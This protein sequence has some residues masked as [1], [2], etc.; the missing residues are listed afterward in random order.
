MKKLALA[1]IALVAGF[2]IWQ[3]SA[4]V[5]QTSIAPAPVAPIAAP[6]Q[7]A[8][9]PNPPADISIEEKVQALATSGT[10]DQYLKAFQFIE[11]CLQLERDK[12]LTNTEMKI[13]RANG[14]VEVGL[15]TT[16]VDEQALTKLRAS[17]GT[18]SGRTRLD[19]YTL[20]KYA[21][22]HHADGAIAT[23]ILK[24]PNG[25]PRALTDQATD[26]QVIEWRNDAL[27][28]LKTEAE[29]GYIAPLMY[30]IT[31]TALLGVEPNT[32]DTYAFY[33]AT[34][35]IIGAINHN[36]GPY[37]KE[38]VQDTAQ[39]L[40]QQQKDEAMVR[41]EQIYLNWKQRQHS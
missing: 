14:K 34:N 22:D 38:M 2:I 36:D 33:L 13:T 9:A 11:R 31:G 4:P 5:A 27:T 12:E 8:S 29:S 7:H 18:M 32:A 41:A 15:E 23:Y 19:R 30:W 3:Q 28:R 20:L 17:C 24:G 26:P 40:N 6:T 25:D 10:P 35:K 39:S 21:M 37:S 16:Q 1:L